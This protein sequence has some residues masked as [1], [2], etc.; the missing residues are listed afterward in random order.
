MKYWMLT[1]CWVVLSCSTPQG[2]EQD[3]VVQDDVPATGDVAGEVAL[4]DVIPDVGPELIADLPPEV[5]P[6]LPGELPVDIPPEAVMEFM[7]ELPAGEVETVGPYCGDGECGEDESCADC[8]DDCGVCTECGNGICEGGE[9]EENPEVCPEDCGSCGDG[10]CGLKELDEEHFCP[11]DCAVVCGDGVCE[12]LENDDVGSEGYC[13]PDCGGCNDG[14]CGYRDLFDPGL[15]WCKDIDCSVWCGDGECSQGEDWELCPVDCGWCGDGVCGLVWDVEEPCPADCTKPCGDGVCNGNETAEGCPSDCGPCGDG[16][17]GIGEMYLGACPW[18]CPPECGNDKCEEFESPVA[19]PED[20]GCV[21]LCDPSWECGLD[22]TGCGLLCGLCPQGAVCVDRACCVPD[23]CKGKQCGD[24]GCGGVCG[25]CPLGWDCVEG[26]CAPPDC[27]PD[28]FDKE[29]GD[30]GC[31]GLCGS[32][33]DGLYCTEDPCSLGTCEHQIAP[34]YCLIEGGCVASGFLSPLSPCHQCQ[35]GYSQGDWTNVQ[36]GMSCGEGMHC[37]QGAC[38]DHQT[39]CDGKECGDDGCGALCG[40][41]E[42]GWGCVDGVCVDGVPCVPNCGVYEC[43]DNGCG[44]SCGDC[45]D[46]LVCTFD[47]CVMGMC[48]HDPEPLYCVIDGACFASGAVNPGNDCEKCKPAL[49]QSAWTA[50][51]GGGEEVCDGQDND[52]DGQ[53]DEDL[54]QAPCNVTNEY[55]TCKGTAACVDGAPGP[56]SAK[57]PAAETC[58]G[59]DDNCNGQADEAGADKCTVYYV[60]G[61]NDGYGE[62]GNPLCLCAPTGK[63]TAQIA[64]DCDDDWAG[65]NPGA[66]EDCFTAYDDNCNGTANDE[67]AVGCSTYYY[68]GD[69]DGFGT[70]A[71]SKCY[72]MKEGSYKVFSSG[73][74]DDSNEAVYPGASEGCDGLDNNCSG[75]TD[76]GFPD[77]DVDGTKDCVD[78][79]PGVVLDKEVCDNLVPSGVWSIAPPVTKNCAVGMVNFNVGSVNFSDNGATLA[80]NLGG[81]LCCQPSGSSASAGSFSAQCTCPGTCTETYTIAGEFTGEDSWTGTFNADYAG[82]PCLDCNNQQWDIDGSR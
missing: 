36:D 46:G 77:S 78:N 22:G 12:E 47:S 17:C 45:G 54:A 59:L 57:T 65:I 7:E 25:E 33:D 53:V 15:A 71:L 64:G 74:C 13:P 27:Q 52:C 82:A 73:D 16:I 3:L 24:D 69:N 79:C 63:F 61:D 62:T 50:G 30:N 38:C 60:D 68:D 55:G 67:A 43:G 49:S 81:G 51:G 6:D 1:V 14:C 10:V 80:V 28:C 26:S 2:V 41:C 5:F 21:P 70:A 66:S 11:A 35:P 20:C 9:P 18:D 56:C 48:F 29:C 72:C 8:E 23:V 76:E 32:C 75:E 58:N 44:G 31:G 37:F 34:L 40:G 4:P 19:C 39:N 42:P